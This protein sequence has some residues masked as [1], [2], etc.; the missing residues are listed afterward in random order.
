MRRIL[1]GTALVALFGSAS[2][3]AI[4]TRAWSCVARIEIEGD[5]IEG[6][7]EFPIEPE[8]F[9]GAREDL[10]DLRII[11][12]EVAE[13]GYVI[14][15]AEG[16]RT[17][18]PLEVELYN[19]TFVPGQE[20]S[21]TAD[22]G[23]MVLKNHIEVDT[24]GVAFL[25][26]VLI[27]GSDDG[28]EWK[29]I[30]DD[31]FL[32]RIGGGT[33]QVFEK[34]AIDL[35]GTDHRYLRITVR[36]GE[37]DPE[38]IEISGVFAFR[39][40]EEPAETADV[41]LSMGEPARDPEERITEIPID[42]RFRNL[43]L[44]EIALDV[45]DANFFRRLRILG[46]QDATRILTRRVED[47]PPEEERVEVP[48]IAVA[49]G[50]IYRFLAAGEEEASLRIDLA[51]ARYRHLLLR[52][53]DRDDPPLHV[54]GAHVT[55]VIR[56][57]AF[58]AKPERIYRLFFGNVEAARPSYDIAHFADRLRA[59]GVRRARLAEIGDNPEFAAPE[60]IIP[61]SERHKAIMWVAL[62]AGLALLGFIVY[63]QMRA[64]APPGAGPAPGPG[65][66]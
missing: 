13:A 22:F 55:R 11:D 19:R 29:R 3:A 45:S 17:R 35:P 6:L 5:S 49:E 60:R 16:K 12:D 61:W 42:L 37:D 38:K 43:P 62:L 23:A 39:I 32:F 47:G 30:R 41:P 54:T 40:V 48:W 59:A 27:E 53:E 56:Y 18:V 7:V 26:K 50:A 14:R 10:A 64:A 8:V 20:A 36:R 57:A 21:V 9:D 58:V 65:E 4:E 52:I 1:C 63:R 46:R 31:A 44:R 33:S 2:H 51:G 25:R 15:A 34:R 66:D 24:P 28:A